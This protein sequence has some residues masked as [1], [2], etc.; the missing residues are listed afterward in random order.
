MTFHILS[1]IPESFGE[2][3]N[4]SILGRAVKNK[5]ISIKI[6]NIRKWATDKHKK[7]DDR[8]FGGGAG[9]VLKV[10]PIYKAVKSLKSC[11][12]VGMAKVK[13]KKTRVILFS[14]RGKLFTEQE[15]KRLSKYNNLI[16]ICGRYE[17]V[18]ERVAQYIADEEISVGNFVLSGGEIPAMI[19]VDS[20][21]RFIPGV[22]GKQ[23]SLEGIKGSYPTYTRPE[24]FKVGKKIW[25]TPKVLLSGDHKKIEEW[26]Q[27]RK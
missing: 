14:T 17:G 12:P 5:K 10:D 1:V 27:S 18:D 6:H 2:Y 8:P 3:F 11:L 4:S 25:K 20:V 19:V 22:L 13:N 24:E 9:M 23:E 16:L 21:S 15:A 26:R 7:V